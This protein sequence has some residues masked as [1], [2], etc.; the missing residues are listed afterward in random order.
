MTHA[1]PMPPLILPLAPAGALD[2]DWPYLGWTRIPSEVWRVVVGA[3]TYGECW[4]LLVLHNRA[5]PV[6][7]MRDSCVLRRGVRPDRARRG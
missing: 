2:G 5:H 4:R 6:Q 7:G 3:P 1:P